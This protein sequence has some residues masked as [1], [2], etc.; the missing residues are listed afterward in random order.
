MLSFVFIVKKIVDTAL[1]KFWTFFGH[2]KNGHILDYI[3]VCV[4]QNSVPGLNL[5]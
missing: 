1:M 2:I 4:R 3:C 5:K